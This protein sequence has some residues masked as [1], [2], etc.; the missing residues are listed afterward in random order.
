L[1]GQALAYTVTGVFSIEMLAVCFVFG[2]A[3]HLFIVFANDFADRK[4]D[5]INTTF[6]MFSGGSR[7]L[8]E[9]LIA[10]EIFL[11]VACAAA[12]LLFAITL[13]WTQTHPLLPILAT[14]A[15]LLMLAY[16]YP[17]F[18]LSYRGGGEWLQ[19]L[20]VGLVLPLFGFH[21]QDPS[22][23]SIPWLAFLPTIAM[24]LSGNMLTS[25]PDEPADRATSKRTWAVRR[26]VVQASRDTMLGFA[27]AIMLGTFCIPW[28]SETARAL[29]I[30]LPIGAL[31]LAMPLLP[32]QERPDARALFA[33]MLAM[34]A[35]STG[36]LVLWTLALL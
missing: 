15:I 10:P 1:Y 4:A 14:F 16:S 3:D 9:G 17:P 24:G 31:G 33:F 11:A 6:N 29:G 28:P 5:K 22:L 25:L 27:V 2:I 19:A 30:A 35:V 18:A 23:D 20:G 36:T 26:G 13:P 21:A 34:G 8:P 32:R 7:I 12:A